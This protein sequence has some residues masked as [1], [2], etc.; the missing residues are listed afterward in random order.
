MTVK[1]IAVL[2]AVLI[3]LTGLMPAAALASG[4]GASKDP[5]SVYD[6][7]KDDYYSALIQMKHAVDEDLGGDPEMAQVYYDMAS[8]FF[9]SAYESFDQ[10]SYYSDSSSYQDYCEGMIVVLEAD[11]LEKQGYLDQAREKIQK[12]S[13]IFQLLAFDQFEDSEKLVDYC[14]ARVSQLRGLKQ[15]AIDAFAK[16]SRTLDAK[17]RYLDLIDNKPLP[18]QAPVLKLPPVMASYAAHTTKK[19]EAYAGPGS[20]YAKISLVNIDE[21]TQ[22]RVCARE[23][24]YYVAEM[25]TARGKV[26]FWVLD[27]R[28]IRDE[29]RDAELPVIKCE[30][31]SKMLV[32]AA[33]AYYGPGEGYGSRGMTIRKGT[34]VAVY[35]TEDAYTLVECKE[36]A[37]GLMIRV[38]IKSDCLGL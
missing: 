33:D 34:R 8:E 1:K 13:K 23:D 10:V 22:L 2:L 20:S 36:P 30:D 27:V 32:K 26:R 6:K 3:A 28:V 16:L 38:W 21:N 7:A 18:T 35:N 12:A 31:K 11:G 5:S 14:S 9:H 19:L 24:Y 25:E 37:S 15:N 4:I 29:A 17:K